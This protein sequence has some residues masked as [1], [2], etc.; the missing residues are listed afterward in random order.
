MTI[1]NKQGVLVTKIWIWIYN[2]INE[3]IALVFL[4]SLPLYFPGW[5]HR[6]I[7]QFGYFWEDGIESWG[8]C[9]IWR[10]KIYPCETISFLTIIKWTWLQVSTLRRDI[11]R[12]IK[13]RHSIPFGMDMPGCV[14]ISH[15]L[16][17]RAHAL[18]SYFISFPSS[19]LDF[20]VIIL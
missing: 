3:L 1:Q 13:I 18:I 8:A 20:V 2:L 15:T 12:S 9:Y 5:P 11:E 16:R 4:F 6:R 17:T 7:H 14:D 10:R 19:S